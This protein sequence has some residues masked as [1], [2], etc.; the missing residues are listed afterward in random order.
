V[1]R[2]PAVERFLAR[3]PAELAGSFSA[4][5]LE[6]VELHFGMRHRAAHAIDWRRRVRLGVARFYVVVLAGRERRAE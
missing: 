2:R 1:V 3:L 6:A 5:Q 4:A